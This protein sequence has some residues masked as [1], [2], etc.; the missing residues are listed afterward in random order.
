MSDEYKSVFDYFDTPFKT[1]VHDRF[2]GLPVDPKLADN[3]EY[4]KGGQRKLLCS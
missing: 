2:C 3:E 4:M 1:G